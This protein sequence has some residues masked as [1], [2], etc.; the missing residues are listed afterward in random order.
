MI[1]FIL[2]GVVVILE[3]F[4]GTF[5]LLMIGIGLAAGGVTALVGASDGA[6]LVVAAIVGSIATYGLRRSKW[7]RTARREVARDPNVNLDIGQTL[8]VDAWSGNAAR[9][10]YRGAQWDVELEHGARAQPGVFVI[11]EVRGSR[12]IVANS[13]K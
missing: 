5:Y 3:M 9:T 11:R 12:L 2:V 13:D 1:W 6:Q 7:G 10:T 8:V 4:T